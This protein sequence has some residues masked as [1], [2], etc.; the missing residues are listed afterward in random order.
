MEIFFLY[1]QINSVCPFVS[2]VDKEQMFLQALNLIKK[3]KKKDKT[4]PPQK[5]Q[6]SKWNEI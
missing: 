4:T 3:K 2:H 6:T 1:L 5:K